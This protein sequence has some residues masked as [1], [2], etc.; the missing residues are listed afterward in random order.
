VKNELRGKDREKGGNGGNKRTNDA[1]N[2]AALDEEEEELD[3]VFDDDIVHVT[4]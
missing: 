1:V 4:G 3:E 2:R